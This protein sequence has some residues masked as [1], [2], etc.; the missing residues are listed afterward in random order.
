[1]A[2]KSHIPSGTRPELTP[3]KHSVPPFPSNDGIWPVY[4]SVSLLISMLHV[5]SLLFK[6][7]LGRL[8]TITGGILPYIPANWNIRQIPPQFFRMITFQN[9]HAIFRKH[10]V[11]N[12]G[13]FKVT[14][15]CELCGAE[16]V[17][18]D[19]EDKEHRVLNVCQNCIKSAQ[20]VNILG[21]SHDSYLQ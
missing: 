21:W 15:H 3:K 18:E 8:S 5:L 4:Y 16:T 9:V 13:V 7:H 19:E 6:I 1:M 11:K 12:G 14:Y 17:L 2:E 20:M 10:T